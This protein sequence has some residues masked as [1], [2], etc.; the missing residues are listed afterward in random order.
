M[1]EAVL[2]SQINV[3]EEA[4]FLLNVGLHVRQ[5]PEQS[6]NKINIKTLKFVFSK[7]TTKIDKICT[8]DLTLCS[9]CQTD[10]ED[11]INF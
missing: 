7:K 6:L 9:K 10:G 2:E 4:R 5:A 11:I 8:V 1:E 3:K